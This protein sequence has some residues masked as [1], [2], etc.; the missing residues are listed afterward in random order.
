MKTLKCKNCGNIWKYHGKQPFYATCTSC[1]RKVKIG[2]QI[3]Y[4][5]SSRKVLSHKI[6]NELDLEKTIDRDN[7]NVISEVE[8]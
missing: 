4:G 8:E 1:L 7:D 3:Q 6:K 5:T 2:N